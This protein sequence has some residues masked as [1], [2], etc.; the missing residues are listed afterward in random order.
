[1]EIERFPIKSELLKDPLLSAI[2]KFKLD[3]TA[4]SV[5]NVTTILCPS[6]TVV[7]ELKV[8]VIPLYTI[9]LPSLVTLGVGDL[10]S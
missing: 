2:E 4:V 5:V 3:V 1:M 10:T 6:D 8:V 7:P 9:P